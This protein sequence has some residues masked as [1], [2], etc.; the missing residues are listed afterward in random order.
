MGAEF[1]LV[2]RGLGLLGHRD[3][4]DGS[5]RGW[6][7]LFF[8]PPSPGWASL[9]HLALSWAAGCEPCIR[10]RKAWT[11]SCRLTGAPMQLFVLILLVV[12][13]VIVRHGVTA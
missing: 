6:T 5:W 1:P 4:G 13:A 12:A 7:I 9:P 8:G 11:K 2:M 10:P 3:S